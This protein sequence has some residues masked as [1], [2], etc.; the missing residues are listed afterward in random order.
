MSI[1]KKFLLSL[2]IL[3]LL[4]IGLTY[5]SVSGTEKEFETCKVIQPKPSEN[6][7]FHNYDSVVLEPSTL[8]EA[9]AI[10]KLMQGENYRKSWAAPVKVPVVFLDTL[11][12]GM[13]IV[14]EGGG[15]QTQSLRLKSENGTLYS[16]RSVTKNP[17]PLV[18]D[19]ARKLGL[20]NIIIDGISAQHPYGALLA[21]S[22]ADAAGILHTHPWMI[23]VPKQDF[24]GKYN[25][26]YGN[27]LFLLEYE[28]EGEKNWTSFKNVE[29][30]IDTDDLQELR[31]KEGS[32]VSVDEHALVR[33]RLL[34]LLIGDWDRHAKQWGWVVQKEDDHSRAIPLPG[35]RDN[36][37]FD[38]DGI[39][40][41][42]MTSRYLNPLVRPFDED[43]DYM[44]GLVYPFDVYF[45]KKTPES[46]F[47][48]EAKKLQQRL[49]DEKIRQAF[50]AWPT[51]IYRFNGKEIESKIRS[52]RDDLV[53][54]AQ[55]FKRVLDE[56]EFLDEPLKGSEDLHLGQGLQHCFT[57]GK[58]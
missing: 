20:E 13:Q 19:I 22:L 39:I 7:D 1:L 26:E 32:K 41:S 24:L 42:I 46:V 50:K 28:T 43:I 29:E 2:L 21:A 11:K 52:R 56:K 33:A 6:M 53:K 30:I 25:K 8:Y 16:L 4:L 14:K 18:P 55:Q 23:F 51:S 58:D 10:K 3:L 37:F 34:D 45:L 36:A 31:Q 48:E 15:H 38:I 5:W 35:D 47:V 17:A 9:N 27:R 49:S 54:Y 40:P 12:G 44:P 57:C